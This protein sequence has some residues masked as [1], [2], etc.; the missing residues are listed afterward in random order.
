MRRVVIVV[1]VLLAFA[2][3][4]ALEAR[5][6]YAVFGAGTTSCGTWLENRGL[7]DH[8][9]WRMQQQ[10]VLGWLSATGH[11]RVRLKDTD[12]AAVAAWLDRYC[13]ANPLES[14]DKAAPSLVR[15]LQVK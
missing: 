3:G 1:A 9:L 11:Y 10:W 5:R 13:A 2:A 6:Q 12:A 4:V 14:L 7:S 8:A 15:A